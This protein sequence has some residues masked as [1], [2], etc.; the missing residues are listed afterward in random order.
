M[1]KLFKFDK[2]VNSL[3]YA[4]QKLGNKT[5]MHKLCKILYFADQKHLSQYGRS[6]T[7]DTYIAMQFGPVPSCVDDILKALR[8]DSFFSSS[9]EIEPLRKSIIFENRF[10]VRSLQAPDMEELSV[11]DI[12]CLDYAIDLCKDKNFEQLTRL[13][14]G[15]AWSNTQRDRTISIKDIL[16]EAG[17]EEAYIEYIADNLNLQTAFL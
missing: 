15:L 7:G 1:N 14:H 11:S 5:D 4:L 13:S 9:K 8:G 16:R 12:K 6:I 17:D 10:I 2:S 3:L